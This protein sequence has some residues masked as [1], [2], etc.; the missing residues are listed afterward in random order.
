MT[1]LHNFQDLALELVAC[2]ESYNFDDFISSK[3]FEALIN[4]PYYNIPFAQGFL[5]YLSLH[6]YIIQLRKDDNYLDGLFIQLLSF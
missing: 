4:T 2:L 6:E 1:D 3:T 5:F